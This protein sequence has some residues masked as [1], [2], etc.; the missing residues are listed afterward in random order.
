MNWSLTLSIIFFI[1]L[2]FFIVPEFVNWTQSTPTVSRSDSVPFST[3]SVD[4]VLS[5]IEKVGF[6]P[7][8]FQSE[9]H[10][11][12]MKILREEIQA[13]T[14]NNDYM[15]LEYEEANGSGVNREHGYVVYSD[16]LSMPIVRLFNER[17]SKKDDVCILISAHFDS[18][19][20]GMG[21]NDDMVHVAMM[22]EILRNLAN[23][24]DESAAIGAPIIFG[25]LESE[26]WGLDSSNLLGKHPFTQNCEY[27]VNLESM[28]SSKKKFMPV[29]YGPK[30][31]WFSEL[32]MD[33]GFQANK[34]LQ[35]SLFVDVYSSGVVPSGTD[36]MNYKDKANGP[37]GGLSGM[38][39]VFTDEAYI[40]HTKNDDYDHLYPSTIQSSGN[41]LDMFLQK[42]STKINNND[43]QKDDSEDEYQNFLTFFTLLGDPKV[44]RGSKII[45]IFGTLVLSLL[46]IS[47]CCIY[48]LSKKNNLFTQ[49]KKFC[50]SFFINI[51]IFLFGI[52][53]LVLIGFV[54]MK[55]P[56][57]SF[58]FYGYEKKIFIYIFYIYSS[59]IALISIG[60]NLKRY[61]DNDLLTIGLIQLFTHSVYSCIVSTIFIKLKLATSYLPLLFLFC[62]LSLII[63]YLIFYAI[64]NNLIL[65]KFPKF[66]KI[67][68]LLLF[69]AVF[70]IIPIFL[71]S[72]QNWASLDLGID[73]LEA[74]CLRLETCDIFL[75][76]LFSL[77]STPHT[78]LILTPIFTYFP[79][80]FHF[81]TSNSQYQILKD[82]DKQVNN[83]NKKKVNNK[84]KK[85][86]NNKKKANNN[87]NK[88]K[89][90]N[91]QN[92]NRKK[93]KNVKHTD[94]KKEN[95]KE[96]TTPSK[97]NKSAF[98]DSYKTIYRIVFSIVYI[99]LLLI[100]VRTCT[101]DRYSEDKPGVAIVSL[102]IVN[103]E[104]F[105]KFQPTK[106]QDFEIY[107]KIVDGLSDDYSYEIAENCDP[108]RIFKTKC[109][110]LKKK[111]G[112]LFSTLIKNHGTISH[113]KK[114]IAGTNQQK[115][116]LTVKLNGSENIRGLYKIIICP[117]QG[118]FE[119]KAKKY[120]S[121]KEHSSSDFN[122]T[123]MH[124]CIPLV[125]RIADLKG[126]GTFFITYPIGETIDITYLT[127]KDSIENDLLS[128][129][130]RL[131]K[132]ITPYGKLMN[133]GPSMYQIDLK[134][135]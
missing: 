11:R 124:T 14:P 101:Q 45:Q 34:L 66:I 48:Y 103:K 108:S 71:I 94:N 35:N 16:N 17:K 1:S 59:F 126:Q 133:W 106:S 112:E 110:K 109:F 130:N 32:L 87:K 36:S 39:L 127:S 38:D 25:F 74:I 53:I 111:E 134:D 107:H 7:R 67:L 65:K 20:T 22:L 62:H 2:H 99:A 40:Y 19:W 97:N 77:V 47:V 26:E 21:A 122:N 63:G 69:S 81:M 10:R 24:E 113:S 98:K 3:F 51:L 83:K 44:I 85:K 125:N 117:H 56:Q 115:M 82:T 84:N 70:I 50:F 131:P 135:I 120:N 18:H 61:K 95:E 9:N 121:N 52:V 119:I 8:Q 93:N 43:F 132:Y 96:K 79:L 55:S 60:I 102:A 78:W 73:G 54:F 72:E 58:N 31:Q 128:F 42:A 91:S 64:K 57:F 13:V 90:N 100:L 46:T 4:R 88:K 116:T 118:E 105:I 86:V 33:K 27:L 29:T 30:Q 6:E 15:N 49:F 68:T 129:T 123:K 75:P 5:F 76:N 12:A 41:F 23:P 104:R 89:V 114:D 28:G 80:L 37:N 92:K